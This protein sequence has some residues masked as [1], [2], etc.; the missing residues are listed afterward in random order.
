MKSDFSLGDLKKQKKSSQIDFEFFL[1]L[2]LPMRPEL[3]FLIAF[4]L[5][6][7]QNWFNFWQEVEVRNNIFI[8]I[9]LY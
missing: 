3:I 2:K 7:T 9:I 4:S 5:S 6:G 8:E 1:I